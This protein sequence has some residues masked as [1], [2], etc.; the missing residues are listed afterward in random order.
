[1]SGVH[2]CSG[3]SLAASPKGPP[4]G[5]CL[6]CIDRGKQVRV[7]GIV[8]PDLVH[9]LAHLRQVLNVL[10][11]KRSEDIEVTLTELDVPRFQELRHFFFGRL[12]SALR[13]GSRFLKADDRGNRSRLLCS[14]L[15]INFLSDLRSYNESLQT[16][17]V[18]ILTHNVSLDRPSAGTNAL[19]GRDLKSATQGGVLRSLRQD[20]DRHRLCYKHAPAFKNLPCCS[21]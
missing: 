13:M 20:S 12:D 7:A 2:H 4:A 10:R 21:L 9:P 5:A 19:G 16:R 15:R 11:H 3:D 17:S 8:V 1:D 14:G 18:G 6:D